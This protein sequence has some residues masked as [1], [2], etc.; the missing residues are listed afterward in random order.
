MEVQLEPAHC[1]RSP[2]TWDSS[3]SFLNRRYGEDCTWFGFAAEVFVEM[4]QPNFDLFFFFA[5]Y[6]VCMELSSVI[7]IRLDLFMY[8]EFDY[9]GHLNQL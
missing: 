7:S 6:D 2:V 1:L 4:P 9:Q 8:G 3:V 5:S